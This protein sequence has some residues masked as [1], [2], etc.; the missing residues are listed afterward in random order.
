L[1]NIFLTTFVACLCLTSCSKAT[2]IFLD[3]SSPYGI[4][5]TGKGHVIVIPNDGSYVYCD[6]GACMQG[7]TRPEG[8]HGV[9]LK[10]F[11]RDP[12]TRALREASEE[13]RSEADYDFT[14]MGRG[15][16]DELR[17]DFCNDYPCVPIGNHDLNFRFIKIEDF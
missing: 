6:A 9:V 5:K 8:A 14:E 7:H 13:D 11:M 3:A 4:W 12:V 17:K 15:M 10:D 16:S 1:K 2:Y